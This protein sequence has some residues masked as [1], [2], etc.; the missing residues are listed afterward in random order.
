MARNKTNKKLK[1]ALI[2]GGVSGERGISLNS[3]RSVCDHL[4]APDVDITPIYINLNRKPY[5]ISRAQLYCNTP[6]DFDF[7]LQETAKPLTKG[8]LIKFLKSMDIAF[9]VIHGDFGEDGE[10]QTILEEAGCPFVGSDSEACKKCFDKHYA[11]NMLAE[12]DFF[13]LDTVLLKEKGRNTKQ[14]IDKFFARNK[15]KRALLKPVI[16]GSSLGIMTAKT[17]AQALKCFNIL[18]KEQG[19]G[20]L[21]IQPFCEGREFTTVILENRFGMPVSLPPIEVAA[22]FT[23][24]QIFDYRMKYLATNQVAYHCP[25]GFTDEENANIQLMSEQLFALFGMKGFARFD[26]WLRPDG[27]IWFFDFNPISG[28]EQNSFFF[29]SSSQVRMTH[30]DVVRYLVKVECDRNGI[31]FAAL[32][33][34]SKSKKKDLNILFGGDTAERQVSLMSGTNVWL[35]LR[36]S[37]VYSPT[38]YLLD[39]SQNVWKLPYAYALNHTVEEITERCKNS[40][41]FEPRR[42]KYEKDILKKLALIPGQN[43]LTDS[44]PVKMPLKKFIKKSKIAFN[45]VHGG[46][47]ENGELQSQFEE[48]RVK[49]NGSDAEAS[50]LCMDKFATGEIVTGLSD[51]AI[52]TAKKKLI[53]TKAL[54]NYTSKKYASLW[55]ELRAEFGTKTVI[56]KPPDDGCSAGIVRLFNAGDLEKYCKILIAK[57]S[58]IDAGTLSFQETIVEMPTTLPKQIMFEE[59]I[60]TDVVRTVGSKLHWKKVTDWIEVTV[61]VVGKKR[62]MKAFN[63]SI[64]VASGDILSLE[65]KFQGGT[66]VNITPPP[67][68]YVSKAV[69]TKAKKHIA[70]VANA[71][72]IGGY[73]RIDAF[74]RIFANQQVETIIIEVNSLPGMTPATCIFHQSAING[75][76][77]YDFIDQIM[78]FGFADKQKTPI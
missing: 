46:I 17:K 6:S 59:Y 34:H 4:D 11:N 3:A 41:Q 2:C 7:K 14:L 23:G 37:K 10:L 28:M 57:T 73:A 26:G 48:N 56:V 5:K 62:A 29:I 33:P 69:V 45:T 68:K 36:R 43:S 52:R 47:G 75:Y 42:K 31:E 9:P 71:L 32:A 78:T 38:P 55:K 18:T 77:P 44:V 53:S 63:P 72:G 24:G 27:N 49:H 51:S 58:Q 35:K 40:K 65:E 13:T 61:G 39:T 30:A 16:G 8:G 21:V 64:T 50:Q 66:G 19:F 67:S 22:D 54:K 20:D 60:E 25:A 15:F 74:V 1:V 70:K 12:N 76:K